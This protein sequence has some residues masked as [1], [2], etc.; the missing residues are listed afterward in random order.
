[1]CDKGPSFKA[2]IDNMLFLRHVELGD[3]LDPEEVTKIEDRLLNMK[4]E[5]LGYTALHAA[6]YQGTTGFTVN[7]T[8][9]GACL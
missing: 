2:Q 4:N 7:N 8:R 9:V 1:M 5:T 3:T 6:A